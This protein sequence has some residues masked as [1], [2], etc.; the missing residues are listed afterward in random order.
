L[1]GNEQ[2]EG[3]NIDLIKN[4]AEQLGMIERPFMRNKVLSNSF[5]KRAQ[6]IFFKLEKVNFCV[7]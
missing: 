7:K 3:Y 6:K 5:K 2:Y 4:I 1:E